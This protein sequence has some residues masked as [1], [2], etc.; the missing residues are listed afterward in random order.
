MKKTKAKTKRISIILIALIIL[1]SLSGVMLATEPETTD[2]V[3]ADLNLYD[4]LAEELEDYTYNNDRTTK[5]IKIITTEISSIKELRLANANITDITGM[6]AFTSLES[7]NLSGNS[8]TSVQPISGLT[9]LKTLNVSYNKTNITDL[10][11]VSSLINLTN[12]NFA[13]SKLSN[14]DFMNTYTNLQVLDVSGNSLT[15]LEPLNGLTNLQRLNIANNTGFN[16]FQ[17]NI[18]NHTGLIELDISNTAIQVLDGIET[19]LRNLETLKLRYLDVELTPIV[20]RYKVEGTTSTYL[21]YLDNLKVLDISYT[22]KSISF[23]NISYLTNLTHLY[24]I[25]VIGK[26]KN[27]ATTTKL[28]LSGIYDLQELQ[29]INLG[30]N[31]I[32]TL[33]GIIY[34]KY[35]NNILVEKKWL[36]ATE[37][38]LQDNNISNIELLTQLEQVITTLNL[39]ENKISDVTP[40]ETCNFSSNPDINLRYQDV[41]L[42]IFKKASVDQYIILPSLFQDSKR[43]GSFIYSEDTD[44][45]IKCNDEI[46]EESIRLNEDDPYLQPGKY[47]VIISKSKTEDDVLTLQITGSSMATGSKIT[48][49]LGT[50]QYNVD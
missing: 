40:L 27:P 3:C 49:K 1:M 45:I 31:N 17:T 50:N 7:L 30:S 36:G 42:N 33:N 24:M 47:N 23:T 35:T 20:A 5:T 11:T 19:N 48:F 15:S 29:Y 34:T 18:C 37:I 8:I 26:W 4:A 43:Q 22:T 39:S 46:D 28:S 14:V 9:N 12:V 44:F 13:S 32:D 2:I 21:P 10:D 25:D 41:T 38:Y 6:E 16:Q